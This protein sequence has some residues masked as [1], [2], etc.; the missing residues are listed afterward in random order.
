MCWNS[1]DQLIQT[2]QI[3]MKMVLVSKKNIFWMGFY[4]TKPCRIVFQARNVS[5]NFKYTK[6]LLRFVFLCSQLHG[7]YSF[8]WKLFNK[9]HA[10]PG[11]CGK[12]TSLSVWCPSIYANNST[13]SYL[14]QSVCRFMAVPWYWAPCQSCISLVV[15]SPGI[16]YHQ[17]FPW[18]S[19][20]SQVAK[21]LIFQPSKGAEQARDG[22]TKNWAPISHHFLCSFSLS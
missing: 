1:V 20:G 8:R 15:F 9:S 3:M 21:S 2:C 17:S 22:W 10:T 11:K 19:T 6:I 5:G 16:N 4:F 13:I 7:K 14:Y 18:Y 12:C